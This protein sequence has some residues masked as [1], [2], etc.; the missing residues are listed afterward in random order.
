MLTDVQI[1]KAQPQA[2]GYKLTDG[3]SLHLYIS[4][5]G[6]KSW[7]MRYSFAGKEKLLTIGPY[8]KV[9]L[10]EARR[11]R[12]AAKD[13]LA[14]GRDPGAVKKTA[15]IVAV[16]AAQQTFEIVARDWHERRRPAWSA[17]HAKNVI[18]SLEAD[19]FP[20][21]GSAPVSGI[22]A[23]EVLALVRKI[24]ARGAVETAHRVRQRMSDVF[25]YAIASGIAESDPAAVV[26]KALAPVIHGKQPAITELADIRKMLAAVEA[27]PGF[28]ITKLAMRL[29][30]L[31]VVRPGVVAAIP[32]VEFDGLDADAPTWIVP[33]ARMKLAKKYK[34]DAE[35]DHLVPLSRQAIEVIAVARQITGMG[36]LVFP[37]SRFAH[38]PMSENALGYMLRRAGYAEVHVPH[39]WRAA[40]SS[41]MNERNRG[42]SDVIE[43]MLAHVPE[44]KVKGAYD[45]ALH[46]ARRRELAQEWADMLMDGLPPPEALLTGRR[47]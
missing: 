3:E 4:P 32:W 7:R 24:E 26:A 14:Q 41:V 46:L 42:D 19:V 35:R 22:T 31:T 1:R 43:L 17:A 9:G 45:R 5:T 36:P 44:N 2:K 6:A 10:A 34:T 25:V 27:R 30:A 29:L 18:E 8:P 15:R 13:L 28:P 11:E 33:A 37:N 21:V 12:D 47:R 39:G 23:P 38:K 16:E 20:V 40:F